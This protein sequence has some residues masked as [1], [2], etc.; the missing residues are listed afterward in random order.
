MIN[1][2]QVLEPMDIVYGQA[3]DYADSVSGGLSGETVLES[4]RVVMRVRVKACGVLVRL[5]TMGMM[6]PSVPC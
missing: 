6:P 1:V 3:R 4:I 2:E 5:V